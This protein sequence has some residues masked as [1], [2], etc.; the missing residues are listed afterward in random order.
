M[1][2]LTPQTTTL[3]TLDGAEILVEKEAPDFFAALKDVCEKLNIKNQPFVA[4]KKDPV[5]SVTFNRKDNMMVIS[6]GVV[7]LLTP[8]ELVAAIG[9]A[10]SP[11]SKPLN[12]FI[13]EW[14]LSSVLAMGI[15][16]AAHLVAPD[17]MPVNLLLALVAGAVGNRLMVHF[18]HHYRDLDGMKVSPAE[19][20]CSL[21]EKTH[22]AEQEAAKE[23]LSSMHPIAAK[24][25]QSVE[26]CIAAYRQEPTSHARKYYLNRAR[27]RE[28]SPPER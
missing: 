25:L 24:A 5:P 15:K 7:D 8:E 22:V 6:T 13:Q 9:I 20:V 3:F 2:F 23:K 16:S 11:H 1:H 26:W 14:V 18:N 12:K 27:Q 19:A 21:M 17:Y 28:A 4:L 10:A